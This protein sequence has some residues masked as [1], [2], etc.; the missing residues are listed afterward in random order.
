MS[1]KVDLDK[2][3]KL[4]LV[5]ARYGEMDSARWWN[6]NGILGGKGKTLLS[7][8]FPKTHRFVRARLVFE[9]AR[10]RSLERFP[11]VPNCATLW[12]LPAELEDTFDERWA[13][14]LEDQSSWE[15]FIDGLEDIGSNLL[16]ALRERNLLSADQEAKVQKM[17]RSAEDRAVPLSGIRKINDEMISLLAAGFS[18]GEDGK[19]AV[20]YARLGD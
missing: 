16:S 20:P 14:W 15:E 6:T 4:R 9:V 3:L 8:G 19:P 17:R 7:R 2:L 10:S 5:V 18:R 1:F 13:H 11:Q 12:N